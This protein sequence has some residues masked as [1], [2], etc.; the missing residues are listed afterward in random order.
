MGGI[1]LH[2]D[3]GRNEYM[4]AWNG[5]VRAIHEYDQLGPEEFFSEHGLVYRR[6]A[7]PVIQQDVPE[8]SDL[9]SPL[10]LGHP[11]DKC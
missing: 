7:A 1:A 11:P 8:E 4:V 5:V 3:R 2:H 10:P 6:M 9:D